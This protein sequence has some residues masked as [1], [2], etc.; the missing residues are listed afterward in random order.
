MLVS[1]ITSKGQVTIP[2]EVRKALNL[3]PGNKVTFQIQGHKAVIAK[4][5][6]STY[7]YHSALFAHLGEWDSIADDEAYHDL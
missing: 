4:L 7:L 5:K 1:S 2:A 3:K 6:L